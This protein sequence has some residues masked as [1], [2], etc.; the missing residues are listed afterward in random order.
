MHRKI[1]RTGPATLTIALPAK[2]AKKNSLKPGQELQVNEIENNLIISVERDKSEETKRIPY[3][4]VLLKDMLEKLYKENTPQ[5]TIFSETEI[6]KSIHNIVKKF[7]GLK[8]V[9]EDKNKIVLNQTLEPIISN[10]SAILRRIYLLI[11]HCFEHNPPKFDDL[12]ELL[13]LSGLQNKD[14]RENEILTMIH[15]VLSS[16]KK[17]IFDEM[18][19]Y[20]RQIF[21]SIYKQKY[22]FTKD[23]A[24]QME[25]LFEETNDLFKTYFEKED[26]IEVAKLYHCTRLFNTLNRIIITNQSLDILQSTDSSSRKEFVVGVC[27]KN[28]SNKFWREYVQGSMMET[29]KDFTNIEFIYKAPFTYPDLEAQRKIINEFIS[30]GVDLIILAP[31]HPRELEK[32]IQKIVKAGIKLVIIDTDIISKADHK[33]IGWDNYKGGVLTAQVLQKKLKNKGEILIVEGQKEGNFHERVTGFQDTIKKHRTEVINA[34]FQQSVAYKKTLN[35][36]KKKKVAAI[37]ATS[38][39][40]ALGVLQALEELNLKIPVCGFDATEEA[41]ELIKQGELLSTID[42]KPKTLGSLA[43]ETA[44]KILKHKTTSKRIEYDVE[45]VTKVK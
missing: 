22:S 27:L 41:R 20:V 17:P 6:P 9:E 44:N 24:T 4:K 10:P 28:S 31:N 13:F 23:R 14:S 32:S 35:Y 15:K 5:I 34:E 8:I 25:N 16:I 30:Q 39:N 29:Q 38:D 45:L 11:E 7:P 40:M 1:T 42:D 3:D 43:I 12:E 19:S 33:Y 26:P 18:Y 21:K 37:F 2:W 36:L